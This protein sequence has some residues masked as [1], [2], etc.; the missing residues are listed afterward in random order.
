MHHDELLWLCVPSRRIAGSYIQDPIYLLLRH[1]TV[2]K[3]PTHPPPLD[4]RLEV[5]K[6][7]PPTYSAIQ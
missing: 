1:V 7:S 4:H 2:R 6:A 5:H 3:L